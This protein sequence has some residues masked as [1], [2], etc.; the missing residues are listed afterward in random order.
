MPI[1]IMDAARQA[2]VSDKTLRRAIAKGLLIAQPHKAN[3]QIMIAEQDLAAY[4]ANRGSDVVQPAI[5]EVVQGAGLVDQSGLSFRISELEA[6]IQRMQEDYQNDRLTEQQFS[7][8]LKKRVVAVEQENEGLKKR[9]NTLSRKKSTTALTQE[10][11]VLG[12][13]VIELER[14]LQD[15]QD[16]VMKRPSQPATEVSSVSDK[17]PSMLPTYEGE[18]RITDINGILAYHDP[19]EMRMRQK[20]EELQTRYPHARWELHTPCGH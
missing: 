14:A 13:R 11:E 5:L 18:W 6:T 17:T 2:G 16:L 15:T 19:D 20:F 8:G 1:N 12:K 10:V 4:M 3:Q 9:L 7:N